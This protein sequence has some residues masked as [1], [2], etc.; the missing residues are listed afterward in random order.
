MFSV[1]ARK[2]RALQ[3]PSC[4]VP[5][6]GTQDTGRDRSQGN[7]LKLASGILQILQRRARCVGEGGMGSWGFS[8]GVLQNDLKCC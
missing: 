8:G 2:S 4:C 7:G 1:V 3:L 5:C 6:A